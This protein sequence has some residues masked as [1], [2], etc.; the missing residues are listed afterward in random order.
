[1]LGYEV[2]EMVAKHME[3][4]PMSEVRRWLAWVQY[5]DGIQVTETVVTAFDFDAEHQRRVEAEEALERIKYL[6]TTLAAKWATLEGISKVACAHLSR[7]KEVPDGT[8]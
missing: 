7:Y 2:D 1:M 5:P 3:E 6:A 4:A 8:A